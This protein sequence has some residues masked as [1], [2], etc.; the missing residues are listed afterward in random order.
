MIISKAKKHNTKHR[1]QSKASAQGG[2]VG[3]NFN[4]NHHGR[5]SNSEDDDDFVSVQWRVLSADCEGGG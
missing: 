4:Y 5:S 1:A 2:Q 3:E